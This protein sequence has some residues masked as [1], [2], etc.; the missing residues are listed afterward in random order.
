MQEELWSSQ[1]LFYSL[2]DTFSNFE[3]MKY[4]M[5]RE[6]RTDSLQKALD[7][8]I[9]R[10]PYFKVKLVRKGEELL[11]VD[12]DAPLLVYD[13]A[14][15]P[16][17]E[18]EKNNEYLFRVSAKG[19]VISL[20]FC[21]AIADGRGV[22]PFY[23]TVLHYYWLYAEGEDSHAAGVRLSGDVI[24][25]EEIADPVLGYQ[26][27]GRAEALPAKN[28]SVFR[29]PIQKDPSGLKHLYSFSMDSDAF[30]R[31]SHEIDG[32]PNAIFALFMSRAIRKFHPEADNI[33]AGIAADF[34]HTVH[35]PQAHHCLIG[36]L[37]LPY[38]PKMDRMNITTCATCFR[39]AMI[40]QNDDTVV[41]AGLVQSQQF[42]GY[43]KSLKT[44]QEKCAVSLGAVERG[45]GSATFTVSYT[46][47]QDYGAINPHIRCMT[48]VVDSS[49]IELTIEIFS[50]DKIFFVT[51]EQNFKN[52]MYVREMLRQL[53]EQGIVCHDYRERSMPFVPGPVPMKIK[54]E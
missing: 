34:R 36:L 51:V 11:L 30:I 8:A 29:L 52:D 23:Q 19:N 45:S 48:P 47:K 37:H 28:G 38:L 5:D 24:P 44:L 50:I 41:R 46:G 2:S 18:T 17:L 25:E 10:Y 35:K 7:T 32:S 42:Y 27:D 15:S 20:C 22:M 43:L 3:Q 1:C 40:L 31:Y 12:N 26:P 4:E 49:V 6:I 13:D 14:D 9:L 39:G 53:E 54:E 21:H 33:V 16:T